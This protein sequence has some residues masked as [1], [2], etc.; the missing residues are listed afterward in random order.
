MRNIVLT[1]F[2]GTGKTTVG[3]VVAE[4]LG[5]VFVDTD[6]L[7]ESRHGAIA[8]IFE[9]LGEESFRDLERA[10]ARRLGERRGLV[11]ATGGGMML[12]ERC[13]ASLSPCS[14]AVCL[15]A[16]AETVLAR[17]GGPGAST[18]PLLACGDARARVLRL[19]EERAS[20]Y[21]R[22]RAVKTDGLTPAEVAG[23]VIEIGRASCGKEC[24]S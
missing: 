16:D 1:G 8:D 7:I 19:L 23:A 13:A 17:V 14:D 12:D 3:R 18:R 11:I 9:Q 5:R 10:L 20:G 21:A 22:F 2:M 24:G 6:E 15:T 4:R